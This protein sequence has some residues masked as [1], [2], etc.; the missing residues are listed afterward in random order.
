MSAQQE[1]ITALGVKPVIDA[2]EEIENRV[3]FMREYLLATGAKGL[4]LGISGGQDSSLLGRLAQLAVE[5]VRAEGDEATFVAV[6]LP[7]GVQADEVDAQLAL[8]FI[9][10]DERVTFN[11]KP[12]TDGLQAA[13]LDATG[14]AI[15]DFNKGNAKA[16]QRM[17]AQYAIAGERG[18]LVLGTDHAAEAVTGFFTKFG[19]GGT[20]LNPLAGLTKGQGRQLLEQLGAPERLYAKAPTADLLDETP[21]QTDEANLGLSYTQIDAYL[22]GGYVDAE[23]A[24]RIE[25]LYRKTEH[26]RQLPVLPSDTWWRR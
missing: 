14:R 21:G 24:A 25:A 1:I 19:D 15:S 18:F 10:P 16:R 9:Q 3:A 17:I 7:H 23:V 13:F 2:A 12:A 26:K 5:G 11:I 6:R 4:V 20:D 22:T 8:D